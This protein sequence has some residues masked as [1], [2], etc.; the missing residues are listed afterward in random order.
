MKPY[1]CDEDNG[2][3]IYLGDNREVMP[4][5][6][7][8]F[9]LVFADP[10]YGANKA[11]WDSEFTMGWSEKASELSSRFM[12]ITPGINNLRSVPASIADHNYVWETAG[13]IS[14]GMTRGDIGFSNWIAAVVYCRR[15]EKHFVGGQDAFRFSV[16]G[17]KPDHPSPKPLPYVQWHVDKFCSSAVLDP[18]MGSGT[19]LVAAYRHGV[20]AVGIEVSEKYCEASVVRLQAE[21]AQG[22]LI[23]PAD[24]PEQY[25]IEL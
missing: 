23:A 4:T 14:N 12:V 22:R 20:R 19:T 16:Q 24:I 21:M 6:S 7:R 25:S 17:E 2:L 3:C 11:E 5:L 8:E 1:W 15:G 10:P 13:F 9:D 18:F